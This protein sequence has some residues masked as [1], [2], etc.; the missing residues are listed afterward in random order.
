MFF[1]VEQ[2]QVEVFHDLR[3]PRLLLKSSREILTVAMAK[4]IMFYVVHGYSAD[5]TVGKFYE[6]WNREIDVD[7]VEDLIGRNFELTDLPIPLGE[8]VI[9]TIEPPINHPDFAHGLVIPSGIYYEIVDSHEEGT[10]FLSRHLY[11]MYGLDLVQDTVA[12]IIE[13][14]TDSLPR[15]QDGVP[16]VPPGSA[17]PQ[18]HG[19]RLDSL[20]TRTSIAQDRRTSFAVPPPLYSPPL[21]HRG[22]ALRHP[23]QFN[24]IDGHLPP[25]F[26]PVL[27]PGPPS[28]SPSGSDP[29]A[30]SD[31]VSLA[32][33]SCQSVTLRPGTTSESSTTPAATTASFSRLSMTAQEP[34][35]PDVPEEKRRYW[36]PCTSTSSEKYTM[37]DVLEYLFS[38]IPREDGVRNQGIHMP[39]EPLDGTRIR[40]YILQGPGRRI[41]NR[42]LDW[43]IYRDINFTEPTSLEVINALMSSTVKALFEEFRRNTSIR[44]EY[45]EKNSAVWNAHL[46]AQ[47]IRL[48]DETPLK[49]EAVSTEMTAE[50]VMA[51]AKFDEQAYVEILERKRQ[52]RFRYTFQS[53]HTLTTE[54]PIMRLT[55]WLDQTG[56]PYDSSQTEA[57]DKRFQNIVWRLYQG[58]QDLRAI[59]AMRNGRI[60]HALH[61]WCDE[62]L[63]FPDFTDQ[64]LKELRDTV[65]DITSTMAIFDMYFDHWLGDTN[66]QW[67]LWALTG[68]LVKKL[69][70]AEVLML[71]HV[72]RNNLP[73]RPKMALWLNRWYMGFAKDTNMFGATVM[74]FF[75]GA[76]NLQAVP[77][78]D[79]VR[80]SSHICGKL[81]SVADDLGAWEMAASAPDWRSR[82]A[83]PSGKPC[84]R[85]IDLRNKL[86]V[87]LLQM[88]SY[89]LTLKQPVEPDN[90]RHLRNDNCLRD[91]GSMPERSDEPPV[92]SHGLEQDAI[93]RL[94][95]AWREGLMFSIDPGSPTTSPITDSE[96]ELDLDFDLDLEQDVDQDVDITE[97]LSSFFDPQAPQ[98]PE[99]RP[100]VHSTLSTLGVR[101]R[102]SSASDFD[103]EQ[104]RRDF[105]TVAEFAST[106]DMNFN[107][108]ALVDRRSVSPR[109][110]PV[111]IAMIRAM[112][113][114]PT[115]REKQHKFAQMLHHAMAVEHIKNTT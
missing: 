39:F 76:L 41:A 28:Y 12:E 58:P 40:E 24:E 79:A 43:T 66:Y 81:N 27:R 80:P 102:V 94:T 48:R 104:I 21:V 84:V 20:R 18:H 11:L 73:S 54:V 85:V 88:D 32:D 65:E 87:I 71:E 82:I 46:L 30:Y 86:R 2:V 99:T 74:G 93:E 91:Y 62:L 67:P 90:E 78:L 8:H 61:S 70:S 69:T 33:E 16:I 3:W 38:E 72:L 107:G 59:L 50:I 49:T 109:T 92:T 15:N 14:W 36:P 37:Q 53:L 101:R 22:L 68:A 83:D 96:F 95:V 34:T 97:E 35:G 89:T 75:T 44:L 115:M 105:S 4:R 103:R 52:Q 17:R 110:V 19:H 55:R 57:F 63:S 64:G 29:P 45:K 112:S 25:F 108:P 42:H 113:S 5:E 100:G 56:G 26:P 13:H 7:A 60:S 111:D 6:E 98:T 114:P 106:I 51:M 23:R 47:T 9:G 1:D 77:S 10:A 31:A